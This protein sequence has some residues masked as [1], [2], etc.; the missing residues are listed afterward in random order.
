MRDTTELIGKYKLIQEKDG[1]RFSVDAVIL[2]D[3][4]PNLKNKK[5]LEIG[6]GN[7]VLPIL[8]VAKEKVENITALEIQET[9]FN[10]AKENIVLN[11]LEEII[12]IKNIDIKEFKEGNA[13]DVVISN[14]PY[15][16]LDGKKINSSDSKGIAR[17]EISLTLEEFIANSKRILKPV[18][19]LYLVH[20]TY[21]ISEILIL[22]EKYNF[23]P[24]KIKFVYHRENSNSNLVLVKAIKGKKVKLEVE[25]P[26]YL[27]KTQ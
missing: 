18:G 21:R 13:Y 22:L 20:R 15:M 14:P 5:T 10:L 4:I 24:E 7:C 8:L 19:E 17:H 12:K 3:F 6:T 11:N 1:F 16:K 26:L 27:E 2:S 25:E 9:V 23:S